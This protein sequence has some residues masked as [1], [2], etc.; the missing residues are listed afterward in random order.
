MLIDAS[1]FVAQLN[2]PNTDNP[3]VLEN[4]TWFCDKYEIEIMRDVLGVDLYRDFM[5]ALGQK[6]DGSGYTNV[7]AGAADSSKMDVKW[8]NLLN[9]FEYVGLDDR[10]HKW[11]GFISLHDDIQP[12]KSLIANFVYCY[13]MRN[14]AI[15][16]LGTT[17][18]VV[19]AENAVNVSNSMKSMFAWNEA[20]DAIHELF[21]YLDYSVYND[22]LFYAEWW[23]QNRYY[24]LKKYKKINSLGI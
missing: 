14:N 3:E 7:N 16:S 10:K 13:W 21:W 23:L 24:I 18:A 2:I 19:N 5:I 17:E 6:S 15:H 1:Y 20:V 9:G 4:L 11:P 12:K 22:Y 8:V